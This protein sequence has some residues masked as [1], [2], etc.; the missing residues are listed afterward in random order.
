MNELTMRSAS[1]PRCVEHFVVVGAVEGGG[2]VELHA[3]VG[4]LARDVRVLGRAL[5]HQVLEQV[6]HAGL[7]VV[8]LARADLVGDVHGDGRAR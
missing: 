5:E 3:A 7:A 8:F 1:I 2:A 6:R 4:E